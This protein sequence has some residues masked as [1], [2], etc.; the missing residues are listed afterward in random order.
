MRSARAS[1]TPPSSLSAHGHRLVAVAVVSPVGN[2]HQ[3]SRY[4]QSAEFAMAILFADPHHPGNEERLDLRTRRRH[5]IRGGFS[6]GIGNVG[7]AALRGKLP[8]S[9][10]RVHPFCVRLTGTLAIV[11]TT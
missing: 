3:S 5:G 6:N 10:C 4:R 11:A 9:R 7:N 8:V 1:A 2:G